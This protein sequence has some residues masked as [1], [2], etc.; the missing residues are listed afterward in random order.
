MLCQVM[1]ALSRIP[2]VTCQVPQ[3]AFYVLPD[4]SAYFNKKTPEGDVLKDSHEICLYLLKQYKVALVSGDA[5]GAPNTL[6]ISYATS[7]QELATA[8]ER[9]TQCLASLT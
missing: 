4:I 9:L 6:R 2:K 8:M 3:G 1:A 7:E 5:F